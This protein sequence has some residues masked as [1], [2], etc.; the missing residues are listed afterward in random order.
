[1]LSALTIIS[2]QLHIKE[3]E[4]YNQDEPGKDGQPFRQFDEA[5]GEGLFFGEQQHTIRLKAHLSQERYHHASELDEIVPLHTDKGTRLYV[6]AKPYILEPDYRLTLGLYPQTEPTPKGAVGEVVGADWVGMRG[7]E[8]G[9]AQAWFYPEERT[10]VL[11]ECLLEHWH[12]QRDPR[13]DETLKTIWSGFEGFLLKRLPEVAHIATPSWEPIYEDDTEAW[14]DFLEGV[15]YRRIGK[16]A[17][18]KEIGTETD[19]L[20]KW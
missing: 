16:M 12:R 17:F 4:H 10:L 1:M 3:Q 7:R 2:S 9:H 5:I 14:P 13:T 11:W 8:V 20:Q 18:G 15:G 19:S 6:M